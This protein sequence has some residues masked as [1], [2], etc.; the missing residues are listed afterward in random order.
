VYRFWVFLHLIGVFGF[1]IS[2]GVSMSVSYRLRTE[3]DPR[4]VSELLQFSASSVQGLYISLA[5]LLASGIVAGFLG[6]WWNQGWI[7][8][9][10]V[11]LILTTLAMYWTARPYY[12]RV[13][14]VARAKA[15]GQTA[16]TDQ[17]FDQVLRAPVAIWVIL[18]GV[19]GLL[20]ILYFMLFKPTLGLGSTSTPPPV[21]GGTTAQISAQNLK[22]DTSTLQASAGKAFTIAFDNADPGVPHN[23]SLYTDSSATTVV[24][25]GA[26]VTGPKTIDYQVKALPAGQFFFRCDVHPTLMTGTLKVK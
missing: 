14:L 19:V 20:A 24:F 11:V 1:L 4:R 16:V 25:K 21:A 10:L 5:V 13:G 22:F 8:G 15:E 2:H 12:R 17:Q 18:I 23:V 7:W 3:R 26:L 6:H 9:G